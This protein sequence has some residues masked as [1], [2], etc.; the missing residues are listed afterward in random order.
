MCVWTRAAKQTN[1]NNIRA[2]K[3]SLDHNKWAELKHSLDQPLTFDNVQVVLKFLR[4]AMQ[5]ALTAEQYAR[6][7]AWKKKLINSEKHTHQWARKTRPVEDQTMT[8]PDGTTTTNEQAQLDAIMQ[9][10]APIFQNRPAKCRNLL[11]TFWK[12]RGD[13]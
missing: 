3:P 1:G 7:Q 2:V 6:I 4:A 12:S 5:R 11:G 8:P 9:A 13:R 10:W